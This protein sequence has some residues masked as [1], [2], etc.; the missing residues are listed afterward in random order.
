MKH[1]KISR[2]RAD[3]FDSYYERYVS[4]VADGDI[5]SALKNQ[6]AETSTLLNKISA[7]KADFSY[8]PEKWS[9][10]EL[11]GHV[12]D[13]ERIF[14]YRALRIARGDQT[15]IEGYEQ[16]DYIKN[17][18]FAKCNLTDLAEEFALIRRANVLMFQNL[19]EIAWHRRGTA[20]DKEISVRALAYIAAGHEIYHVNILKERY[21]M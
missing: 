2:P 3:E 1:L 6:I 12:I 9:V 10:K 14:A 7:E 5:V 17:A 8:A 16:D 20:N 15:P 4:L 11:V 21:L 19:S 18:E 13:T